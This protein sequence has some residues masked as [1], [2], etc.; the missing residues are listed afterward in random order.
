MSQRLES[1]V[2]RS[3][4]QVRQRTRKRRMAL[5]AVLVA[6]LVLFAGPAIPPSGSLGEGIETFGA[7]L[8]V[9]A[10]FG[11]TWCTL[12]IGGRKREKLVVHG[13]YS[14]VRH[15]LYLFTML[16]LVGVG[17]QSGSLTIATVLPLVLGWPLA[18]VAREEDRTLREIFGAEHEAY[19]ARVPALVPD[20]RLWND[21]PLLEVRPAL[22]LRT[23]AEASLMLLAVPVAEL[24][25]ALQARGVLPVL[26]RLR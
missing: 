19:A 25:H 4:L 17:A 24:I 10:V 22:A 2:L 20:F 11:R 5:M 21:V 16:A 1:V 15:P 8:I 14:V 9:L 18:S 23:F 13:P 3:D 7:L 26:I 6:P 12:Y